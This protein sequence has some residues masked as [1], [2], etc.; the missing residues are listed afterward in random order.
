[1]NPIPIQEMRIGN[2]VI[3]IENKERR[4]IL[5]D[6]INLRQNHIPC[7]RE[8]G[9]TYWTEKMK[10]S[11]WNDLGYNEAILVTPEILIALGFEKDEQHLSGCYELLIGRKSFRVSTHE[12]NAMIYQSD[13]GLDW[14]EIGNVNTVHKLQNLIYTLT[15]EELDIDIDKLKQAL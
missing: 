5:C 14:A 4:V 2:A 10:K 3:N 7:E 15:D 12:E 13:I 9:K 11:V 8:P 1:M 6:M